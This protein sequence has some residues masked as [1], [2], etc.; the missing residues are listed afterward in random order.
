M[1][2]A[3]VK[4]FT[5]LGNSNANMCSNDVERNCYP[6][7][8]NAAIVSLPHNLLSFTRK[9]TLS[10]TPQE[11]VEIKFFLE[12]PTNI[13]TCIDAMDENGKKASTPYQYIYGFDLKFLNNLDDILGD[14]SYEIRCKAKLKNRNGIKQHLFLFS[15]EFLRT[16][17][18]VTFEAQKLY[19]N[20]KIF[21]FLEHCCLSIR[22]VCV[23]N[24]PSICCPFKTISELLCK[25]GFDVTLKVGEKTFTAH[26]CILSLKSEVFREMF[27]INVFG[28]QS[29]V[30]EIEGFEPS[31]VE[32]MLNFIYGHKIKFFA[33]SNELLAIAHK[34]AIRDL[35]SECEEHLLFSINI[36]NVLYILKQS[37]LYSLKNLFKKAMA[38]IGNHEDEMVKNKSFLDF[39]CQNL[40]VENTAYTLKLSEK[41]NLP[42][43]RSS[44]FEFAKDNI[45]NVLQ[46]NEFL[47][48]FDSH[49][50]VMRDLIQYI[51]Q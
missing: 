51:H 12:H 26:K 30:V 25:Q 11:D 49:P 41:Y 29:N 44:A 39:L 18:S 27:F 46:H 4:S 38:F 3:E 17:A 13:I 37:H 16:S 35:I 5:F 47:K 21:K 45:K 15:H 23:N 50:S 9:I 48:L 40:E 22:R 2:Y 28:Y 7:I 34:Y 32:A 14:Y 8:V 6:V 20:R 36:Q 43:V 24:L 10:D 19:L 31:I 42:D 1:Y 33:L